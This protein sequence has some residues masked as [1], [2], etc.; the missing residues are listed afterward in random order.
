ML[1]GW[2]N[3]DPGAA[4]LICSDDD[5][6]LHIVTDG[7]VYARVAPPNWVVCRG[8]NATVIWSYIW[9]NIDISSDI[10]HD[11]LAI[12]LFLSQTFNDIHYLSSFFNNDFPIFF[13]WNLS[14]YVY[15]YYWLL[16]QYPSWLS[17]F[18]KCY[19]KSSHT[20]WVTFGDLNSQK[21]KT[22]ISPTK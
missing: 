13:S 18:S 4:L 16:L 5:S 1:G 15:F 9:Q 17:P 12:W 7:G 2:R 3:S 10:G 19:L 21:K 6:L 20:T 14:Q 11:N 22:I 8:M